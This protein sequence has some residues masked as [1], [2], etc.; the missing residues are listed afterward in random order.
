MNIDS[1]PIGIDLG[2]T[3]SCVSVWRNGRI[4]VIP[5]ENGKYLTP[6]IVSYAK[7]KEL[8]GDEAKNKKISFPECT[9]YDVKRLIGRRYKDKSVQDDINKLSY[10]SRIKETCTGECL[11]DIK[12]I[13]K[14]YSIQK[15]SS[16]ILSYMKKQAENYLN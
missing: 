8:I 3:T 1:I 4:E 16:R 9:F 12:E 7:N 2:T 15:I 11:I 5:N 10:K 13:N 14:V 6:S